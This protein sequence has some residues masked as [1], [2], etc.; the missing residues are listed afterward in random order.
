VLF[1]TSQFHLIGSRVE[2]LWIDCTFARISMKN[3]FLRIM[4]AV[5]FP[6]R[7]LVGVSILLFVR[8]LSLLLKDFSV[9]AESTGQIRSISRS[10][11]V[12]FG[13]NV[14]FFGSSIACLLLL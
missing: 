11:R 7:F 12:L 1:A 6:F 14:I 10:T 3:Q 5:V 8:A 9:Q 2:A 13:S 4:C